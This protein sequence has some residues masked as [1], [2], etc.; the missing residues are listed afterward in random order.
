[1]QSACSRK[2]QW[3][4]VAIAVRHVRQYTRARMLSWPVTDTAMKRWGR[5]GDADA[6]AVVGAQEHAGVCVSGERS[7]DHAVREEG[8]KQ[9]AFFFRSTVMRSK[10]EQSAVP[11]AK[12]WT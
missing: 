10:V 12:Q 4:S 5:S 2:A 8:D 1:M 6:S 9:R 11:H 3:K 7:G